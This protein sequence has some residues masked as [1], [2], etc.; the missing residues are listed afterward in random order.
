MVKALKKR[1]HDVKYLSYYAGPSEEYSVIKPEIL[2]YSP[3]FKYIAEK[4][5]RFDLFDS[6]WVGWP[7][8][9]Q[10]WNKISYFEPDVVVVRDYTLMSALALAFGNFFDANGIIQQQQPKYSEIRLLKRILNNIYE[11]IFNNPL[12]RITPIRGDESTVDSP[13]HTY[14][15]PFTVDIDLYQPL[16]RKSYF[17]NG[18]I[19]II[20][21]GKFESK[22]KNHIK[23]LKSYKELQKRY[24]IYLTLVGSLSDKSNRNYQKILS[25]IRD[26]NLE[27]EISIKVNLN[28]ET[29]QQRYSEHD[30]FVLPS[31]D[32]PAAISPLEAM[33]AGLPVICSDS[34]GTSEYIEEGKNGL[35]FRTG[36]EY[37][38]TNTIES[39]VKNKKRLKEMS[40]NA[41]ETVKQNHHPDKYCNRIEQIINEEFS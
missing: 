34:N 6:K 5:G 16:D 26:N 20:S 10:L 13:P 31:R 18:K 12:V 29:L 14:Y 35:V 33:A 37:D 17:Q 7:P 24:P 1:G 21:V 32:E 2:G 9:N 38:L 28:Y 8:L 22:R 23:L 39:V 19:N 40:E 41:V 25:Y 15:V 11:Y 30:L 3:V 27:E 4:T 36:S